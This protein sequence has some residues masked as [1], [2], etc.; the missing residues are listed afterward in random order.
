MSMMQHAV[1]H[2]G[3][4]GLITCEGFWPLRK[5]QVAGQH[6]GGMFITLGYNVEEQVGLIPAKRQV[7]YLIDDQQP[8]PSTARL[9][10]CLR[11]PCWRAV[12]SCS[13]K[14]AA[15]MKRVLI[16]AMVAL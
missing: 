14:S 15:V 5:W 2:C 16:P 13:I 7:T 1:E 11:R 9:K 8:G 6:D 12:A 4:Q 3:R 10:Y